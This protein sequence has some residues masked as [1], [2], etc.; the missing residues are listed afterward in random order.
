[1]FY[2]DAP[3]L[4]GIKTNPVDASRYNFGS[5]P[6][7]G[8]NQALQES[9]AVATDFAV[10]RGETVFHGWKLRPGV[11]QELARTP[12]ALVAADILPDVG[13]KGVDL[14]IGPDVA[15][16][17]VKRIVDTI[18]L[19]SGDSDLVPAMKFARREG[20]RVVLDTMG[21]GIRVSM[22]EHSDLVLDSSARIRAEIR[23]PS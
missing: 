13:Q 16:L 6:A 18:V 12:R 15:T 3:P 9:L 22:R 21:Q 7:H 2:Y 20:V 17:A 23:S 8:R 14:R 4:T 10:R 11:L 5:H 19:V 1:M